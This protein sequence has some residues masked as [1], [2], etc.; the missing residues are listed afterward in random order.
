LITRKFFSASRWSIA[1]VWLLVAETV[2][3][4]VNNVNGGFM[5]VIAGARNARADWSLAGALGY[6][7]PSPT[8]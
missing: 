8:A 4:I 7:A 5:S 2:Y 3:D 1:I 6:H